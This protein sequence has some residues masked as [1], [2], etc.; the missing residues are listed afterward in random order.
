MDQ[1]ALFFETDI[2]GTGQLLGDWPI[3][4]PVLAEAPTPASTEAP[5]ADQLPFDSDEMR[6]AA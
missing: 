5:Q 2:A 3:T 1:L 4:G 6:W